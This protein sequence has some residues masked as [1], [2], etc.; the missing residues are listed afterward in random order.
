MDIRVAVFE[1]N[2]LVRDALEAI[3]NGTPGYTCV[4]AFSSGNNWHT[5]VAKSNPQVILMDIE[6]PGP[7]GISLTGEITALYPEIKIL[8]QTVFDDSEK[9]FKALCAGA[10][11]YILKNDPPQKYLNAITE[12]Y[13]GKASINA[14]IA[15]KVVGFFTN[16][17]V[18]IAMPQ[19]EDYKLTPREQ[20]ILK[21]IV[22]GKSLK[23][24]AGLLFIS[25]DTIRTHSKHIYK[26][27]QVAGKSE[28]VM[29][30][31]QQGI[32]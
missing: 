8:I 6:M 5:D 10:S 3:L 32:C 7:D 24:I 29:K 15:K 31:L 19:H 16:K 2:K 13:D 14:S 30:A 25:Y 1:D 9:I 18:M 23:D 4:G 28:A 17:N 20:E 12:V 21:C 22:T 27:L 26:K 11:G